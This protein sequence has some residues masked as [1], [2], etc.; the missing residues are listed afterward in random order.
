MQIVWGII[1]AV[2]GALLVAKTEWFVQNFGRI[3][4]CERNLGSSGG[5]RLGYKLM[6]VIILFIGIIMMTGSGD[7]FFGWI[8][9]P[10][11][12]LSHPQQ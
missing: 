5:T 4:W 11:T 10:L 12:N 8:F 3:E 7:L 9:A 1:I 2:V 6:G